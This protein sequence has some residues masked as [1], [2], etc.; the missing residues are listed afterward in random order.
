MN[1]DELKKAAAVAAVAH[2][3]SG[4]KLG[5]GTGST[6][7]HFVDAVGEKVRNGWDLLCVPTSE[8]TRKQAESLGIRL[9]TLDETPVLDVTID[10]AD[11]LDG[12]LRLIKGG[13][14]ALLREKIVASSSRKM[15]VIADD[16][17]KVAILGKFPLPVEVVPF[18]LK[19]TAIKIDRPSPGPAMTGRSPCGCARASPSSPTTAMS[20]SIALW[21]ASRIPRNSPPHF[22]PFRASSI[23]ACSSEWRAL[24]SSLA[25][26]ASRH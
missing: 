21:A 7:K 12:Q 8:A 22:L 14:G 2:I 25:Q 16:S 26:R 19:A 6:A 15:I 1:P 3:K 11:E 24:R 23:T 13:G 20:F 9:T 5:L 4:M 10:G 18:G 17:K